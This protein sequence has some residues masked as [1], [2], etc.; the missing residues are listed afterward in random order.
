MFERTDLKRREKKEFNKNSSKMLRA[1]II[2]D[3]RNLAPVIQ[4]T[5]V[6]FCGRERKFYLHQHNLSFFTQRFSNKE[7][8]E[9]YA[10]CNLQLKST[11]PDELPPA[12]EEI[13]KELEGVI[14]KRKITF[15]INP[16]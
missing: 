8:A 7:L 5:F 2:R 9:I 14:K 12:F 10:D 6:N 1:K 15:L 13:M 11:P 4:I 16:K 3:I